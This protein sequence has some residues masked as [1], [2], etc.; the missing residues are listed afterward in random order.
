M[1]IMD[2]IIYTHT[3]AIPA[4]LVARTGPVCQLKGLYEDFTCDEILAVELHVGESKTLLQ[5]CAVVAAEHTSGT[6]TVRAG[7]ETGL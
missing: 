3:E 7:V 5:A 2:P 1:V 4:K 6:L